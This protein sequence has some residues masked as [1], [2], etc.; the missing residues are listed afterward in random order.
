MKNPKTKA[1]PALAVSPLKVDKDD[2]RRSL[3]LEDHGAV[4]DSYDDIPLQALGSH[5][6]HTAA[7]PIEGSLNWS[8]QHTGDARHEQ[9]LYMT[10]E[11][12]ATFVNDPSMDHVEL[13][14]GQ[15]TEASHL[16]FEELA[17]PS[18]IAVNDLVYDLS[19]G[20]ACPQAME[21]RSML[22]STIDS[23]QES[24]HMLHPDDDG[25]YDI[26]RT[27]QRIAEGRTWSGG[28]P[29]S[30][31]LY[32]AGILENNRIGKAAFMMSDSGNR[33]CNKN[34][35]APVDC[36]TVRDDALYPD[37]CAVAKG[38]EAM[39]L[40]G[41]SVLDS[42]HHSRAPMSDELTESIFAVAL[43]RSFATAHEGKLVTDRSDG[44]FPTLP[45]STLCSS[46]RGNREHLCPI[47]VESYLRMMPGMTELPIAAS[48]MFDET[49][50]SWGFPVGGIAFGDAAQ[51]L[52]THDPILSDF[53]RMASRGIPTVGELS[54][55]S[56]S[57]ALA[58]T[59]IAPQSVASRHDTFPGLFS[60]QDPA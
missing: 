44:D 18:E 38:D 22:P 43:G 29:T 42:S 21:R 11:Q 51:S 56:N 2:M 48:S 45:R 46:D 4:N 31:K 35:Q 17:F 27:I 58:G 9:D 30:M 28:L 20:T 36:V 49:Q 40:L 57:G 3:E 59:S 53:A 8:V 54:Y 60:L 12:S 6:R 52:Q 23:C 39:Q 50:N 25:H 55:L 32:I 19:D 10:A 16:N 33:T 15:V 26:L 13:H 1:G 41:G 37:D 24:N 7:A 47:D 5:R 34:D 14:T